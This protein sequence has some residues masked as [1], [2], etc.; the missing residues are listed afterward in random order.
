LLGDGT[1]DSPSWRSYFDAVFVAARKPSFFQSEAPL[2]MR[3]GERSVPAS[4]PLDPH[5]IYE[6]GNIAALQSLLGVPGDRV[7]YVG[8]HIYGDMLRTKKDSVWRTALVLQELPDEIHAHLASEDDY[9]QLEQLEDVRRRTEEDLVAWNARLV[10]L[11]LLADSGVSFDLAAPSSRGGSVPPSSGPLSLKIGPHAT[12]S[13]IEQ[14]RVRLRGNVENCDV[15]LRAVEH[16]IVE[17]ETRIDS[18]FHPMWGPMLREGAG[19]TIFS[20]QVEEYACLYTS[21][22]SNFLAYAPQQHFSGVRER[23][24]HEL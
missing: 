4:G 9:E 8:D 21:K 1:P 2:M 22:V 20:K 13:E 7:L 23:M 5:A 6:G 11:T 16:Q 3:Q 18:R 12:A 14:E 17:I 15:T 10:E 19:L 24:P